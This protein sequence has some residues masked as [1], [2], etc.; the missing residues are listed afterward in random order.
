[1]PIETQAFARLLDLH[2]PLY[3]ALL[4]EMQW[5]LRECADMDPAWL[6]AWRSSCSSVAQA[7][8]VR[9]QAYAE[10][11][12]EACA[13]EFTLMARAQPNTN[14]IPARVLESQIK[15]YRPQLPHLPTCLEPRKGTKH[16]CSLYMRME[17]VIQIFDLCCGCACSGIIPGSKLRVYKIHKES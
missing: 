11:A 7:F 8:A 2:L 12:H 3:L 17:V 15:M 16:C 1:M 9:V 14:A 10:F 4:K 6:L 13:Q 5:H